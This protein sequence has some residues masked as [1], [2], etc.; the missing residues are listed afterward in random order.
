M[1][2]TPLTD[3]QRDR[4]RI[5]GQALR[6][7]RGRRSAAQISALSGVPLD[8]LRKIERGA[9]AMPAFFTVLQLAQALELDL[10]T[11]A[12]EF[13]AADGEQAVAS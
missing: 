1:V 5:L 10:N 13:P 12:A 7:A 3:E 2:R 8:T 4:G 6:E 11:L 9:I